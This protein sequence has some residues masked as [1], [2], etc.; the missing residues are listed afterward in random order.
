MR[1]GQE[2]IRSE[3]GNNVRKV[4]NCRRVCCKLKLQQSLEWVSRLHYNKFCQKRFS[5]NLPSASRA[6]DHNYGKHGISDQTSHSDHRQSCLWILRIY[7]VTFNRSRRNSNVPLYCE[8][9]PCQGPK[10]YRPWNLASRNTCSSP[11]SRSGSRYTP[12][13]SLTTL[14]RVNSMSQT[15]WAQ[16]QRSLLLSRR[17][18]TDVCR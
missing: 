16:S 1:T 13:L 9:H 15:S 2:A 18:I 3:R 5:K 8:P 11:N 10:S 7:L 4:E 14:F 6:S 17:R 12:I